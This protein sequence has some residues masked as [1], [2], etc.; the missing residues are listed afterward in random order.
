MQANDRNDIDKSAS[1]IIHPGSRHLF[2]YWEA[3]RAERACPTRAEVEMAKLSQV[4]PS[5]A[6]METSQRGT[7]YF[8]LAGSE[9]C[10]LLQKQVTGEDALLGFDA[11][12]RD[13]VGKTLN[14]AAE[15]LQPALIRMRLIGTGSHTLAAE[16]LAMPVRDVASGKV[17]LLGGLFGFKGENDQFKGLL[18]RRELVSARLIW[19]EHEH[20]DRLLEQVGRKAPPQ[21]T[22]IQGGLAK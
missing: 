12:E 14:I 17:Q 20:G 4:L 10:E 5:V 9:V 16:M 8:R 11:F 7:W 22:V 1:H 19:T 3:L 13:V 21:L 6:I 18:L 2:R 15:R